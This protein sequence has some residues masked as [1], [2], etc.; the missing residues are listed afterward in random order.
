MLASI[1]YIRNPI[2]RP[3]SCFRVTCTVSEETNAGHREFQLR[4]NH[5]RVSSPRF[6]LLL[7]HAPH[8]EPILLQVSPLR[9]EKNRPMI[10]LERMY[11][12]DY[13]LKSSTVLRKEASSFAFHLKC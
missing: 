13:I 6:S 7:P 11:M 4:R 2:T 8:S 5:A 3:I 10:L 1:P 9:R 12:Q